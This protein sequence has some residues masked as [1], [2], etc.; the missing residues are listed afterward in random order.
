MPVDL[1]FDPAIDPLRVLDEPLVVGVFVLLASLQVTVLGQLLENPGDLG[2]GQV[3]ALGLGPVLT[4]EP[5]AL[6]RPDR[7][8]K[9]FQPQL[10]HAYDSF[11]VFQ[12]CIFSRG[13]WIL[14]PRIP[15]PEAS[16]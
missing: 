1:I 9:F 7:P 4:E 3:P 11:A 6:D 5:F 12:I 16:T 13:S 8:A 2:W 10:A 14:G 15:C